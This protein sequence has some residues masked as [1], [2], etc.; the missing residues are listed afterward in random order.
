MAFTKPE[1]QPQFSV[2]E[3]KITAL[4]KEK[5][6]F[7]RSVDNRKGATGWRF[8]DGP[9]FISGTPHYGH[10]KDFVVK[11]TVPRYWTMKGYYAP[12]VWGWDCHGLPIENKVEK[13]LGIKSKLEVEKMGIAKYIAEC[14]KYTSSTSAEWPWYVEKMGRWIDYDHAYR[15]M[16]QDYM[17]TVWWVF[18]NLWDKGLI[19]KGWRSSL[20]STDS[21][22]PVSNF[23]IAMDNS[24]E[25]VED[26]AV[27]VKFKLKQDENFTAMFGKHAQLSGKDVYMISWTTTPWTLP[28]NFALA[29][30]PEEDYVLVETSK[31]NAQ[32]TGKWVLASEPFDQDRFQKDKIEEYLLPEKNGVPQVAIKQGKKF[33]HKQGEVLDEV[34][35]STF[36]A[37]IKTAVK[38]P[39]V[40]I[41]VYYRLSDDPETKKQISKQALR[42][43]TIAHLDYYQGQQAGKQ[44]I[45]ID[46]NS[47]IEYQA[48][49]A[50]LPDWFGEDITGI[51][52]KLNPDDYKQYLILASQLAETVLKT[53]YRIITTLKGS[54]LK[55]LRYEPIYDFFPGNENDH[56]V[57]AE[58]I[59][60]VEDG[61]GVLHVAP[62]FGEE[63]FEIGKKYQLSFTQDIDDSG[64]LLPETGSFA[65]LY[66]RDAA[67]PIIA[68][69][70]EK[71][72]L[73]KAEK[74]T[75]RLPFYRYENPLIYRA[76]ESWFIDVQNLKDQLFAQNENINWIPDHLKEGRFKKGIEM[77]PDWSISRSRFWATSMPVWVV[78]DPENPGKSKANYGNEDLI[79]IGSRDELR[80]LA[81]QKITK[82]VFMY[83]DTAAPNELL[84]PEKLNAIAKKISANSDETELK[85]EY[86]KVIETITTVFG[87]YLESHEGEELSLQVSPEQLALIR[88]AYELKPLKESFAAVSGTEKMKQYTMYFLGTELLNLHRN[89]IDKITILHPKSK[90]KMV[91][92][93]EVLDNWLESG[94]MPFA[95]I[96][97]P[98]EN[99]EEFDA[100]YP[101]DYIVEYIAQTRAWFYV[102]H[103]LGV[104]LTGKNSFKNAVTSGVLAGN[105]GRK[106]SKTYGNYPDPRETLNKYGAEAMRWYFLT[107]KLIM[108]EDI[109]FDEK[110]LR[111][112]LRLYLLPLWNIYSFF[113]TYANLHNWEPTTD[114]QFV[115]AKLENKLDS[116]VIA[117]LQQTI[118]TVR[119]EMDQYFIPRAAKQLEEFVDLLSRQYVRRSRDRFNNGDKQAFATLYYCLVEVAKLT[120]PF[121]PFIAEEFYQNLV[122]NTLKDQPDS[123][124]LT[125]YPEAD[126]E[127]LEKNDLLLHQFENLQT[128]I[129]LGQSLRTKNN[130]KLRQ[131]LAAVKVQINTD[132][133]QDY[134][135]KEWMKELIKQELNV[136]AVDEEH[137]LTE[138]S[139]WLNQSNENGN[140]AISLDTNLTTELQQEGLFRELVRYV[141]SQR[142]QK[143]LKIGESISL[144]VHTD[145]DEI[146]AMVTA[147][148]EAIGETVGAEELYL[149]N[150]DRVNQQTVT[151][152][153]GLPVVLVIE[154]RN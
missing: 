23:E 65:G 63:D 64:K 123:V 100:S 39:I 80:Q 126:M 8:Y 44:L 87:E 38:D 55:G 84:V 97:Y 11:D 129:D 120:A 138:Q 93:P 31:D 83:S 78:E 16:D 106:M 152:I 10:I 20:Y 68:D 50:N 12:R 146:V 88:H 124:H 103:V 108:G 21:A 104:A 36:Q 73:Y 61:T 25:D 58:E 34:D 130:L 148:K 18:K 99:K 52:P 43:Q 1:P 71:D 118:H 132:S 119:G 134:E 125:D 57:Y 24:Y 5:D 143:G 7:K 85:A 62:A 122:V 117:K 60:T 82:V 40:K 101:A 153:N 72:L 154:A 107:S 79:V 42:R 92:V 70:K 111:D 54:K 139:G 114:D 91:R 95:Q 46:F 66:L 14:Y 6:I 35:Q 149:D 9:P 29:V 109:N 27:T 137:T 140:I 48:F 74:Y 22:T 53:D 56:Q 110:S 19:Y 59:V 77:A 75:H 142:K 51:D 112:Q 26:D 96:H 136:H 144:R 94:A 150:L 102:M 67:G 47:P 45:E 30:H 151:K 4:W 133:N 76:Q 32:V 3:E 147:K 98:F 2:L 15:T 69:L 41:R 90:Q 17:E 128:I 115:F 145:S 113:I 28:A 81:E 105:D 131:P 89:V 49:K 13:K 37:L 135:L 33:Y 86:A 121:T 116:W 141:Q 127:Y